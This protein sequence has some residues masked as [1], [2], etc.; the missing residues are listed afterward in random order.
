MKNLGAAEIII[1]LSDNKIKVYHGEAKCL[2]FEKTAKE[3]TWN[4]IWAAIRNK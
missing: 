4:E 3:N 1:K 2:L